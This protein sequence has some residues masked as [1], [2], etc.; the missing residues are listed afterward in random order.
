MMKP[1]QW[2]QRV[3]ANTELGRILDEQSEKM[4]ENVDLQIKAAQLEYDKNQNQENLY[5][6][7]RSTE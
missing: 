1:R 7:T 4:L 5:S 2:K 3:A 6:F